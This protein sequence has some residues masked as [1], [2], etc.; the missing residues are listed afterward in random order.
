MYRAARA[1]LFV[2]ALCA[3]SL[4][5]TPGADARTHYS[6]P[7]DRIVN[8]AESYLGTPY[9][10]LNCSHFTRLVYGKAVDEW[11]PAD[12][13]V[14][15]YYGRRTNHMHKGDLVYFAEHGQYD[16]ITHVGIYYGRDAYGNKL[17]IHSS[18]FFN[19]VVVS[20]MQYLD[21]YHGKRR[22]R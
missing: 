12:T 21:G 5:F 15:K 20:D 7:Q 2:C 9:S 18:N 14:Q 11:I 10:Q 1:L 22:I 8:V 4:V 17:V 6:K 3:L 16:G 19:E 13:D